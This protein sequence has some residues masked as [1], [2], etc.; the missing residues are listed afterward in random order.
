MSIYF[1]KPARHND[2]Q[3]TLPTL[4]AAS[5]AGVHQ[6]DEGLLRHHVK[7]QRFGN[8]RLNI[9]IYVAFIPSN[10]MNKIF[11]ALLY[12]ALQTGNRLKNCTSTPLM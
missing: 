3:C 11:V 6:S 1:E 12:S 5:G 10:T 9:Y 2:S 4:P 7:F 8:V